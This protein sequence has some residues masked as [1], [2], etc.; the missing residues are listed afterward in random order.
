MLMDILND[1]T[2]DLINMTAM[3]I[4]SMSSETGIF[5]I[6]PV[7]SQDV[8]LASI[9]DVPSKTYKQMT[10]FELWILNKVRIFKF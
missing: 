5:I 9:P 3:N 2:I 7:N 10:S 4:P 6:S 1:C 8:C